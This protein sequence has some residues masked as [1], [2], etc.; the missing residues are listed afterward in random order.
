MT[1]FTRI[2]RQSAGQAAASRG[3]LSRG[4]L[5]RDLLS[6]GLF[7]ERSLGNALLL[8]M[9]LLSG[10]AQTQRPS[11][12]TP[13]QSAAPADACNLAAR[14]STSMLPSATLAAL[15]RSDL[16]GDCRQN[17]LKLELTAPPPAHKHAHYN[18]PS[19][20]H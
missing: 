15:F 2:R 20:A 1:N 18:S 16:N 19:A 5:S 4:L 7:K 11:D 14:H 6:R 17:P 10:C 3:F 12:E 9:L 13:R 8:G